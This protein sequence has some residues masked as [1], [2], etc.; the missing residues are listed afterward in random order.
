MLG[1]GIF[2]LIMGLLCIFSRDAIWELTMW[3]VIRKDPNF[4]RSPIWDATIWFS[5]IVAI[6]LGLFGIYVHFFGI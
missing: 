4:K 3:T 6:L 5:G 1:S 2:F